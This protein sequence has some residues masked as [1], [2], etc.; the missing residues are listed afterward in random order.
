MNVLLFSR[1]GS[2]G[3]SSRIR[4]HQYFGELAANGI[5]VTTSVLLDDAYLE[6]LY[7]TGRKRTSQV[8]SRYA[9]R[10]ADLVRVARYDLIW[11]EKELFPGLPAWAERMLS[12]CRVP[13]VVDYDDAV[14]HH[15]DL[16]RKSAVRW[17][18]G[19][20][21]DRVMRGA[22]TVVVGNEYL[23]Q[24]ARDVG[25]RCIEIVPS[26]VDCRTYSI[27][28]RQE[29]VPPVIGWIGT[30]ITSRYLAAIDEAL[31][32]VCRGDRA[33]VVLVGAA[34]KAV[35]RVEAEIRPWSRGTEVS[36]V[37]SF[38]IGIMPIP[39]A[40]WERGKCGY[41]LIQY[42]ACG[43]AVVASPVGANRSIL[44]G[45]ASGVL[46]SSP[47]EWVQALSLLRDDAELRTKMGIA[48]R[49]RVEQSYCTSVTGP[50]LVEILRRSRKA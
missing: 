6:S 16:H 42:M 10:M 34:S 5:H 41:K 19:R 29:N 48:G 39:D 50:R 18:L 20:K 8:A 31:A 4:T 14:F 44:A 47:D 30:P 13:Y 38:D 25:A 21:V 12:L 43:R 26:A 24:R 33:R 17:L 49:R 35:K 1:Y 2:L 9:R 23:A 32:E 15:Y 3:A 37:Q 40:P 11:I 36:D 22:A 28:E 27:P 7:A 45:E 46:A